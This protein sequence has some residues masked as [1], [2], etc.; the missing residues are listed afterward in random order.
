MQTGA[1]VSTLVDEWLE[2]S[3]AD[4]TALISTDDLPCVVLPENPLRLSRGRHKVAQGSI[5]GDHAYTRTPA[6]GGWGGIQ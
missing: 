1:N 4:N 5:V 6:G 3:L 2:E